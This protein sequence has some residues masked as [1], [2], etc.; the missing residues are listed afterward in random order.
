MPR[1]QVNRPQPL[2]PKAR[3]TA[4]RLQQ[5][6]GSRIREL[7]HERLMTI[8]QVAEAAEIHP[9]YL[10]SVER[11][12]RNLSLLNIWRIAHALAVPAQ[13]LLVGLPH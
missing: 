10:G 13:A 7:R 12:E 3:L 6:V 8:E 9:N 11:G 4:Q 5:L 2:D 1:V